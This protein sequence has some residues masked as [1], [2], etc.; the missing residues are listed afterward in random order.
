MPYWA[1]LWPSAQML[2]EALLRGRQEVSGHPSGPWRSLEIGCGVGL[3]GIVALA[4]GLHV[5]FSDYDRAALGF[6][7]RN[8]IANGFEPGGGPGQFELLPLDWRSPPANLQVDLLLASD[9]IYEQRN[10]EPLIALIKTVLLPG[11]SCWLA[12]P[13][14]PL[15]SEFEMALKS[16]DLNFSQTAI[17]LDQ[18][19]S[20]T[21]HG[22]LFKIQA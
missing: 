18:I 2:G 11:G 1:D 13:N 20:K 3:P 12:D 10:L 6:A 15:K 9:V 5:V 14:R 17:Q 16:N 8:A 22:T 19:D 4:L 21:V 7:E